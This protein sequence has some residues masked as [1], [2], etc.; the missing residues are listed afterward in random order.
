MRWACNVYTIVSWYNTYFKMRSLF[1]WCFV[2]ICLLFSVCK[3]ERNQTPTRSQFRETWKSSR[4][5]PWS[6]VCVMQNDPGTGMLGMLL[7]TWGSGH[8]V[9]YFKA[10]ECLSARSWAG[11][12]MPGWAAAWEMV[13][14]AS[15]SVIADSRS[16]CGSPLRQ[17]W[18]W[19][20]PWINL[21]R[22]KCVVW[23][24]PTEPSSLVHSQSLRWANPGAEQKGA[25]R[26]KCWW[27]AGV[28]T[29]E[30][31]RSL[32]RTSQSNTES[33]GAETTKELGQET[34]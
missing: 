14:P 34:A 11:H 4:E 20:E 10:G 25:R 7:L 8:L 2:N 26:S 23:G 21:Q 33:Q 9:C 27:V 32:R 30:S 15:S 12:G 1:A 19:G 22:C 31:P 3:L 17:G 29:D 28:R 6:C 24:W 5:D 16:A 13:C 18:P